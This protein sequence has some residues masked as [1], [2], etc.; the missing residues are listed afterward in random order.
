[1][2]L[3]NIGNFDYTVL[4]CR[5]MEATQA[6]YCD[7]MRFPIEHE[8]PNWVSFRVGATL[9]ALRP[10]DAEGPIPAVAAVQLAFRVA[11]PEVDVCHAELVAHDVTI[12]RGPVDPPAWRHLALFFRDP[13]N[14][15]VEVYA[16]Y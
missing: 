2:A 7:V 9:L 3:G 11:P 4:L 1:M 14:N 12:D 8:R 5:D 16:E 10:R 13:E 6:F 15:I